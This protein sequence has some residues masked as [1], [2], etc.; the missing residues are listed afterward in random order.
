ML[1]FL[2]TPL[3][4]NILPTNEYGVIT[5]LLAY[6]AFIM[7]I[8][9][10]RMETAYFRFA[11]SATKNPNAYGT[12]LYTIVIS[13]IVL[14]LILLMSVDFFAQLLHYEAHSNY[15]VMIAFILGFD[16]LCEIPMAR[17]R[18]ENKPMRFAVIRLS[19]IGL[20]IGLN[21]FFLL[22]CPWLKAKGILPSF[23]TE[24][25]VGYILLSNVMASSLSLLLLLP[26]YLDT[27]FHIEKP[28]RSKM[29]KYAMPLVWVGFAGIINETLDRSLLKWLL[30]GNLIENQSALGEYG[31]CYK[32]AMLL[33]L[34]TQAFRYAA[35]P[36]FFKNA[37]KSDELQTNA[38][39]TKYFAIFNLF[40]F[41]GITLY[42]DI[43]KY[44][45][46]KAYWNG[47]G[48]VPILLLANFCLGLYYNV[49]VWYRLKDKT[50]IGAAIA[51]V[52]A[53]ITVV[54]NIWLIPILGYWGSAWATLI[55]YFTM[56]TITWYIGRF[57]YPVPYEVKTI[58]IYL[59]L[60]LSIFFI[61]DI[62]KNTFQNIG[63]LPSLLV[64]TLLMVGFGYFVI[65]KENI[66]LPFKLK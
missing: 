16:A 41:L 4:T 1:Y 59:L 30:P 15:L 52:G 58:G 61:A 43:V 28:L 46:G 53:F 31:A 54:L 20:N 7:V 5:E 47:L 6:T 25:T 10:Y 44:F 17:L 19:N 23:N 63:W 8:F 14:S 56:L 18:L 32:L 38:R 49:S 40:G 22:V 11:S 50:R 24:N 45:I 35:E 12:A 55:C 62:F 29:F 27:P 42:I 60:A 33:S 39:I 34:F 13:T 51:F 9:T 57:Y 21:L 2:L 3:Y 26:Y 65:K 37:D 36:F 64:N 48:V 66:P